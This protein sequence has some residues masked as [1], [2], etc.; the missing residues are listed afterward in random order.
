MEEGQTKEELAELVGQHF[1]SQQVDEQDVVGSFF[2]AA[3]RV[4]TSLL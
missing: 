2:Q 4:R 1:V 3:K